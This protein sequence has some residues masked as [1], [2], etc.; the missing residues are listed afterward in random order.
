MFDALYKRGF[1]ATPSSPLAVQEQ[2][3]QSVDPFTPA[4]SQ[5][6]LTEHLVLVLYLCH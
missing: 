2:E 1:F 6:I 3:M 4:V 5:E